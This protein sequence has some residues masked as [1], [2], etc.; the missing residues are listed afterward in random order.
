MAT[1]PITLTKALIAAH[2][3]LRYIDAGYKKAAP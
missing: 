3:E 1:I 2:E